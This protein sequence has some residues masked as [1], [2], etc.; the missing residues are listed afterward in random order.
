MFLVPSATF[1]EFQNLRCEFIG[2]HYAMPPV[3]PEG[4]A[5]GSP[6]LTAQHGASRRQA[7]MIVDKRAEN[8]PPR[9][10]DQKI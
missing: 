6:A 7:K 3:P 9:A 4:R 10:T 5:R 1:I 2:I 8:W